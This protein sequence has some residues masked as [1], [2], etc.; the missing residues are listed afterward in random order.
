[1]PDR[2]LLFPTPAAATDL[3]TFAG[4]ASRLGDGAVRL[5][6]SA[7]ALVL[8]ASVLA[9]RTLGEEVPTILGMRVL[10]VDPELLCDLV[11]E[12]SA[13]AAA[14]PG[15]VALPEVAVSAPWAGVSPPRSG[16]EQAG[17]IDA[18]VLAARA[19]W[20]MSAVARALPTGAGDEVVQAVRAEIWGAPD[21][22]LDG[23]PRGLAFAAFALGFIGGAERAAIR[24]SGVWTRM[25]LARGHVLVRSGAPRGL[26]PVRTT[27]T[28]F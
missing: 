11:V 13:L 26:T 28:G 6:A 12:A 24:R 27:G 9:P 15:Q 14:G 20:G 5:R 3:L 16:W 2:L 17:E 22:A 8:T 21:D 25:S 4:R 7:G 23:L 10:S 19:Q 18:S 1:M